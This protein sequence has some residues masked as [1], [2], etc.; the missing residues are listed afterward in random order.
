MESLGNS[1]LVQRSL[2]SAENATKLEDDLEAEIGN[3]R[4][5]L[6]KLKGRE[7]KKARQKVNKKI[8]KLET[9]KERLLAAL[10]VEESSL[11]TEPSKD[12]QTNANFV[13]D[14]TPGC[15]V[16]RFDA[17]WLVGCEE[18]HPHEFGL[19][20]SKDGSYNAENIPEISIDPETRL[21]TAINASSDKFLSFT[22]SLTGA[23]LPARNDHVILSSGRT[24]AENGEEAD[25]ITFLL[26]LKPKHL[27]D[28]CYV[29]ALPLNTSTMDLFSDI[30]EWKP[31]ANLTSSRNGEY[32]IF[33]RKTSYP[34][35]IR[36]SYD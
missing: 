24:V 22:I 29:H 10:S 27:M 5:S 18:F 19:E 26:L 31:H 2:N 36:S 14:S 35:E 13:Q 32:I 3:L 15:Y 33:I 25:C 4:I 34:V 9:E 1:D 8:R 21:M 12:I 11:V 17:N 20:I 16:A 6:E 28:I 7:Y 23:C 30:K